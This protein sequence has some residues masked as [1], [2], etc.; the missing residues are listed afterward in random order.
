MHRTTS[1]AAEQLSMLLLRNQRDR[2]T[3]PLLDLI[4]RQR[5]IINGTMSVEAAEARASLAQVEALNGHHD[6]AAAHLESSVKVLTT[7]LGER[8]LRCAELRQALGESYVSLS[9]AEEGL[10]LLSNSHDIFESSVGPKDMRTAGA[11]NSWAGALI[12]M[13]RSELLLN[14]ES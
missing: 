1:V 11:L 14:L 3:V 7:L 13:G 5:E 9:L 2:E 10:P 6:R 4:M 8:H 12:M